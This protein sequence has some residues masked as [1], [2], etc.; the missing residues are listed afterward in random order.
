MEHILHA[1]VPSDVVQESLHLV[2]FYSFQIEQSLNGVE[3]DFHSEIQLE[4]RVRI[5]ELFVDPVHF[6][7]AIRFVLVDC[8]GDVAEIFEFQLPFEGGLENAVVVGVLFGLLYYLGNVL[9]LQ[10]LQVVSNSVP[11]SLGASFKSDRQFSNGLFVFLLSFQAQVL[12]QECVLGYFVVL[13]LGEDSVLNHGGELRLG[14]LGNHQLS[15]GDVRVLVR[16]TCYWFCHY[17]FN[18]NSTTD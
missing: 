15:L 6:G 18:N 13:F 8:L 2:D 7:L 1:E 3:E 12:E 11:D 5:L 10:L 17:N 14:D 16:L 4:K 9:R